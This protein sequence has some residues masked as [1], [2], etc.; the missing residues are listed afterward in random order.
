MHTEILFNKE[1]Y[2]YDYKDL[3]IPTLC[4]S[5]F[6]NI[7]FHET[8]VYV[9]TVSIDPGGAKGLKNVFQSDLFMATAFISFQV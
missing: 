5:D 9:R 6:Y 1:I 2:F 4:N 8:Y 3:I 7:F